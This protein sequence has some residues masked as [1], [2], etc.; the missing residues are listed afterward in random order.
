MKYVA[1]EFAAS[2]NVWEQ[3]A[4]RL[5]ASEDKKD[6]NNTEQLRP[7]GSVPP[8]VVPGE[9]LDSINS[10]S[11]SAPL[12]ADFPQQM[13]E[14]QESPSYQEWKIGSLPMK[15]PPSKIIDEPMWGGFQSPPREDRGNLGIFDL[16]ALSLKGKPQILDSTIITPANPVPFQKRNIQFPTLPML[17]QQDIFGKLDDDTL[18]FIFYF[19]QGTYEQYLAAKELKRKNWAFHKKYLTWFQRYE[20]PKVETK[21]KEEGSYVYFDFESGWC[22]KIKKEFTI[23][24]Q[25]LENELNP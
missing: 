4:N 1:K 7:T 17:T 24:F 2:G 16:L 5:L 13:M 3:E 11:G 9:M 8:I 20:D 18:F 25:Q 14:R 22:K 23:E 12:P 21:E 15:K 10:M 6:L 19:Q